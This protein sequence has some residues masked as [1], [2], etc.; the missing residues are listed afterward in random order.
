MVIYLNQGDGSLMQGLG[1]L[2]QGLGQYQQRKTEQNAL[3]KVLESIPDQPSRMDI[4]KAAIEANK[5]GAPTEQIYGLASLLPKQ[6][7]SQQDVAAIRETFTQLGLSPEQSEQYAYLYGMSPVGGQSEIVRKVADVISRQGGKMTEIGKQIDQEPT[8]RNTISGFIKENFQGLNP[9]ESAQQQ[10]KYAEK[11]EELRSDAATKTRKFDGTLSTL[12][13][14]E[15]LNQQGGFPAALTRGIAIKGDGDLRFPEITD[16]TGRTQEYVKLVN[17]FMKDAKD[18]FGS[19]VTNF[20]LQSFKQM[21]PTLM[22]SSA[23]RERIIKSMKIQTNIEKVLQDEIKNIYDEYG[24]RKLSRSQVEQLAEKRAEPK[25][26]K[27]RDE[28]QNQGVGGS[29]LMEINGKKGL[30]PSD[31]VE[32]ALKKGYKKV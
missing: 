26:A 12:D 20:D 17:S 21:L 28:F 7:P 2:G 23:G 10:Q 9:R 31:K 27:L 3:Q 4:M 22:N 29:V 11:N 13:R 5:T 18:Y 15:A 24:V 32:A 14:M 8:E 19:R 6:G 16:S 30:V 25:L 1:M